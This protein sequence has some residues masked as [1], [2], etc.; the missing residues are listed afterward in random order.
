[1]SSFHYDDNPHRRYNPLT[2]QWILVSPHRAKRPWLGAEEPATPKAQQSHDAECYLCA[3]NTRVGGKINPHYSGCYI[4]ENDFSALLPNTPSATNNDDPLF[5]YQSVQGVSRVICFSAD[6]SKTLPQLS[7]SQLG[8]VIKAWQQQLTDLGQTYQWVQIFENKGATMGCSNPH[9]HGQIWAN[10]FIPND[11]LTEDIQQQ[12]YLQQHGKVLLLDYVQKELKAGERVVVETDH[13]VA[14]VPWWAIWP[15]ETLL[16]PK[17]H[18][19]RLNQLSQQQSEDLAIALKK[20]TTRYDNLFKC[21]FPY[22]MGWH[23]APFND[24]PDS[25][26]QLH[27]HFYPPLLR[28]AN[29]RK[30]MAGYE[31][32]AEPQRDLTAEQAA[33]RLRQLSETNLSKDL[34]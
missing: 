21:S 19:K 5:T 33:Q 24:Q 29:V 28:S 13:W 27:A 17:S 32:L 8:E 4:F 31:M 3:G 23:G 34:L 18:V 26:W 6:H 25:H 7:L 10:N 30:F 9:P 15:F 16:L 1:M 20:L 22:T 2:D 12:K 11:V 14:V